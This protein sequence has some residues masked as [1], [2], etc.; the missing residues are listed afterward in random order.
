MLL[1]LVMWISA[2]CFAKTKPSDQSSAPTRVISLDY[3]AD[4]FVLKLLPRTRI[5]ALSP[6]AGKSFSYMREQASGIPLIRPIAEEVLISQPDLVVRSYG[7]GP[8]ITRFLERAGVDVLQVDF[9][10][11]IDDVKDNIRTI[12]VSLGVEQTGLEVLDNMEQRLAAI[13]SQSPSLRRA[14]Y[15]TPGGVTAGPQTLIHEMIEAAGLR[16]FQTE[17]GWRQIPLEALAY[18]KPDILITAFY[19][20]DRNDT[21]SWSASNHPMISSQ[22]SKLSRVDLDGATT[23]CGAWFLLD[24]IE[25]MAANISGEDNGE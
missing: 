17:P 4:Q 10:D 16:N 24:A 23:S 18:R 8:N 6:D 20:G 1:L 25:A 22:F 3:C 15:V 2:D 5:L 14:L 12:A 11:S 21:N 19:E 9:A 13:S 7:G